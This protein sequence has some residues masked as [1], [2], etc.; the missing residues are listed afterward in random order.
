MRKLDPII[1]K[2]F[3]P[4]GPFF[5]KFHIKPN[6]LTVMG[7]LL[8]LFGAYYIAIGDIRK[9]IIIVIFTWLFDVIDGALAKYSNHITK[10]GGFFDSVM[11]RYTEGMVLAAFSYFYGTKGDKIMVLITVVSLIGALTVPYARARAEKEIKKCDIGIGDR[12]SRLI[13]LALFSLLNRP[14]IGIILVMIISHYTVLERI[15]YTRKVL[16]GLI[17][18]D[19]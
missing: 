10:F 15:I 14:E 9:G 6:H 16:K 1:E 2:T 5:E 7:A 13:S 18:E 4:L 11:D 3:K 19:K 12:L 17:Q 8:T